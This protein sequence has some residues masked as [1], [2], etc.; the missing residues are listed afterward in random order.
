MIRLDVE[1]RPKGQERA[2]HAVRTDA[3]GRRRVVTYTTA[4]TRAAADE[5]RAA[6]IAAGRPCVPD[7]AA[8]RVEVEAVMRRPASHTTSRGTP[9][10][11]YREI[12]R[13]PDVDNILKLALDAL[14][15]VCFA[16]DSACI[17]ARV[18]KRYAGEDRMIITID[19][20]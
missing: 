20:S 19:W 13:T 4:K 7:G 6:W 5:I 15:P 18:T 11:A 3:T 8:F 1:T 9:T 17:E 16:D 12:P 10:R 14:Q 2:R